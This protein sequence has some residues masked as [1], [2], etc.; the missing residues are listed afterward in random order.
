MD[1]AAAEVRRS[2]I[3]LVEMNRI[4]VPDERREGGNVLLAKP[5]RQLAGVSEPDVF[6]AFRGRKRARNASAK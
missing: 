5:K 6:E 3:G 4:V 1:D 2:C